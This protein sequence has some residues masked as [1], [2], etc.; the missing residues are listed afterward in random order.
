MKTWLYPKAF[1]ISAILMYVLQLSKLP[2][3]G[4]T[5]E[6]QGAAVAVVLLGGVFWGVMATL[7]YNRFYKR[8]S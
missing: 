5:A 7:V 4:V 3:S 2:S 1:L 8:R 6:W